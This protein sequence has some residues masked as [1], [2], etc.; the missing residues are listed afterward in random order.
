MATHKLIIERRKSSFNISEGTTKPKADLPT[1]KPAVAN[2]TIAGKRV[3]H[4]SHCAPTPSAT[5]ATIIRDICSVSKCN[6]N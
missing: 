3:R 6:L 5:M 1:T 4:A 2:N